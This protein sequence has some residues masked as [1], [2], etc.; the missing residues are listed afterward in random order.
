[1][2]VWCGTLI[3]GAT[4]WN[5]LQRA[6][7]VYNERTFV[8]L[9]YVLHQVACH[10]LLRVHPYTLSPTTPHHAYHL[11]VYVDTL[12]PPP[13]HAYHLIVHVD[14]RSP[15]PP[16]AYHLIVYVDT[17]FT[18]SSCPRLKQASMRGIRL[19]IAFGDYLPHTGGADQYNR[20]SFQAGEAGPGC[21]VGCGL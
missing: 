11:I 15:P 4:R 1:M 12:S 20:W 21:R 13:P 6:P 3:G 19:L 14:T 10:C 17:H 7:G 16:H 2:N 9:D 5:A 18:S 8:G